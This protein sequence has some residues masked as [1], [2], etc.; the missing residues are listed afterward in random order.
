[1]N[2][3][4]R[5]IAVAGIL[6][7]LAFEAGATAVDVTSQS[8]VTLPHGSQLTIEFGIS[9][10]SLNNPG[11]SPF[12]TSIGLQVFG[13]QMSNARTAMADTTQYF[14]DYLLQGCLESLDGF[15]SVPFNDPVAARL[16]YAPGAVLLKP[17]ITGSMSPIAVAT[18]SQV[19]DATLSQS[20]FGQNAT[21]YN[22][23]Y[24]V[25]QN[26]GA[27][28]DIGLGSGYSLRSAIFEP[29]IGGAGSIQ[30][31]GMT[32]TVT[33]GNSPSSVPE[34]GTWVLLAAGLACLMGSRF[35]YRIP[36]S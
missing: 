6:L 35:T 22:S 7:A 10:Y 20:L 34:P 19:L 32:R 3:I 36:K 24:I 5:S 2:G 14:A 13:P 31:T 17:G 4:R 11:V 15:W 26:A 12:P 8:V 27:D 18:A 28:V 16:G 33:L 9:N 30:T 29:G 25:L 1:M 21:A 23:A